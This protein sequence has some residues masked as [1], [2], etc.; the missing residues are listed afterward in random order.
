MK[1][2]STQGM[3]LLAKNRLLYILIEFTEIANLRRSSCL[4]GKKRQ[5]IATEVPFDDQESNKR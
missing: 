3:A 1:E 5:L 2:L 4:L